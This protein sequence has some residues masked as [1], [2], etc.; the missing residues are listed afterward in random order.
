MRQLLSRI[1]FPKTFSVLALTLVIALGA[2]G[3]TAFSPPRSI[4]GNGFLIVA[5]IAAIVLSVLALMVTFFLWV[6][7]FILSVNR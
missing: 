7:A 1:N 2:C 3:V 5:E 4:A 6:L